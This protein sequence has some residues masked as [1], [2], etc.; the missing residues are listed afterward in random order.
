MASFAFLNFE[1]THE[2]DERYRNQR[3]QKETVDNRVEPLRANAQAGTD[4]PIDRVRN[5]NAT[6][7]QDIVGA[8]GEHHF[9]VDSGRQAGASQLAALPPGIYHYIA[10][11][12]QAAEAAF[13]PARGQGGLDDDLAFVT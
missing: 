8:D 7:E 4:P 13:L 3:S 5:R 11:R 1:A 10:A 2:R 6:M 12:H 9:T